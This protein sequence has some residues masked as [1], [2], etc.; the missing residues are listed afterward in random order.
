MAT[1]YTSVLSRKDNGENIIKSIKKDLFQMGKLGLRCY[2]WSNLR[3]QFIQGQY[4]KRTSTPHNHNTDAKDIWENVKMILEGSELKR[5]TGNLSY[6]MNLNTSV[7]SKEKTFKDTTL[8]FEL[9]N[10][11]R[12]HQE[13]QCPGM[14]LNS[15]CMPYIYQN[16][17][18]KCYQNIDDDVDDSPRMI[19]TQLDHILKWMNVMQFGLLMLI[20][21]SHFTGPCSWQTSHLKIQLMKSGHHYDSN[22]SI[23]DVED[24][25][26]NCVQCTTSSVRNDALMSIL[27]EMHGHGVQSRLTNKPDMVAIGYKNPVCLAR[28]KQAQSALYNGHVLVTTNHTP[29]VIHDSED[30]GVA[31]II[32]I[33]ML[34]KMQALY[35]WK[36]S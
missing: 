16:E 32:G 13:G 17:G 31:E 21:G 23:R 28:A 22:K 24:N 3:V 12:K 19:C 8:G 34:L 14:Q 26:K 25:R 5:M 10:D 2:C 36:I 7:K 1:T 27:D 9:I 18:N 4:S 35:V 15:N 33:E 11:M 29:T 20:E 6:T 30:T